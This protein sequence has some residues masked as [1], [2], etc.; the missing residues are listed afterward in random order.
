MEQRRE[1][2]INT[3][4]QYNIY[5]GIFVLVWYHLEKART[6]WSVTVFRCVEQEMK[7]LR[8]GSST[9]CEI[10][11]TKQSIQQGLQRLATKEECLR[12]HY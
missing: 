12:P 1:V 8:A 5:G 10:Q 2:E 7:Q 3:K 4:H 6:R 11:S 9:A